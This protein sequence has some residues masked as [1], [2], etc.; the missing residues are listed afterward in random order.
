[1]SA[2]GAAAALRRAAT[3]SAAEAS[4]ASLAERF[5]GGGAA[6]AH[7]VV[8]HRLEEG[9]VLHADLAVVV[10]AHA[11]RDGGAR[12]ERA[13]RVR[14]ELRDTRGRALLHARDARRGAAVRAVGDVRVGGQL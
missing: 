11:L 5:A 10:R 12:G 13:A 3:N 1:M 6:A 14:V 8:G 2:G 9:R 4:V 7:V